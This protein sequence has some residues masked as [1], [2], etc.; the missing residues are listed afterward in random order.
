MDENADKRNY[1]VNFH[2]VN[3]ILGF[4]PEWHVEQGI[5][6]VIEALTSGKIRDYHDSKYSNVKFLTE[7]GIYLLTQNKSGWAL[8]NEE[9]IDTLVP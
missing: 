7:E 8:L 6:Q 4:T 5:Q 3:N 1:W 9:S 2:K